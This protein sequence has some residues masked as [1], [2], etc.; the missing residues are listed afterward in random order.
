MISLP[1]SLSDALAFQLLNEL[2]IWVTTDHP[3]KEVKKCGV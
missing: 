3:S 1:G 2:Q